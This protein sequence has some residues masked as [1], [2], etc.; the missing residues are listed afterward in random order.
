MIWPQAAAAFNQE[1][2][3]IETI[4][5]IALLVA[6]LVALARF[7]GTSRLYIGLVCLLLAE[8]ELEAEVYTEGSV[9]FVVLSWIDL[10]LDV[11]AVRIVLAAIVIGGLLWHGI[12]NGIRAFKIR[13]PFLKVFVLA[14]SVAVLAQ[15]LEEISELFHEYL[16]VAMVTRL[17]VMEET[18]EMYFSI[19]ILAAVLIG[20][21]KP[22]S[23]EKQNDQQY[24]RLPHAR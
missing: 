7:R 22:K 17:F 9:P 18:L 16:S 5:A 21:P 13:A 23:E 1:G 3:L 10:V 6:G 12:P 19:G 20:W 15:L 4:S 8:R 24:R 2:G 14:G 11:T